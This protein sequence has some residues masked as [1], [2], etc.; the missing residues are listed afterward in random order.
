[1]IQELLFPEPD[2]TIQIN[3][4]I[5]S[6]STHDLVETPSTG[7]LK[8]YPSILTRATGSNINLKYV[9]DLPL[10][11]QAKLSIYDLRG[12]F[13]YNKEMP[14]AGET[15]WDL[16]TLSSGIY[17]ISLTE[18]GKNLARTRITVLK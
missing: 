4:I 11:Q 6:V 7:V 15:V 5:S 13:L 16:S 3:G 9:S 1:M 8:L 2:E 10:S 12:R 17:F 18:G 14:S